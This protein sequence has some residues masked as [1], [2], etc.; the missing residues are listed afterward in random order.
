[1]DAVADLQV[2]E[3]GIVLVG[4]LCSLSALLV[5]YHYFLCALHV[6]FCLLASN[7]LLALIVV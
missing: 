6:M 2:M 4:G 1:M 7:L 3:L 5:F